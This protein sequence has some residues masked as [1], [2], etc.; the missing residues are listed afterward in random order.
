MKWGGEIERKGSYLTSML[1]QLTEHE[2]RG[3]QGHL[4][5][6]GNEL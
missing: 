5:I 2:R 1:H 6:S 4:C 3:M